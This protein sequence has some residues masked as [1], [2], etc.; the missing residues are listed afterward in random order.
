MS[1]AQK[2][3][4]LVT[5]NLPPL[6]GGMENLLLHCA[7]TLCSHY[8]LTVVGPKGCS[9]YL[10]DSIEVHEVSSNL[11]GFLMLAPIYVLVSL[12]RNRYHLIFGGSGLMAPSCWLF[13]K[14]FGVAT[15]C[16]V[17]GLDIVVNSRIY[18]SIFVPCLRRQSSIIVNSSNTWRLC[19]A[20]GIDQGKIAIIHPGC[21]IPPATDRVAA[22]RFLQTYY[23]VVSDFCMLFVGRVA[24]RKGL[25]AF[26]QHGFAPLLLRR[27]DTVL[28]IAGDSPD[29]S[30]AHRGDE[31][32]NVLREVEKNAWTDRVYFLGKV[33]NDTL[34]QCYAGADCLLFPLVPVVG[35]VEG[36]GMVAI[37][38]A[39]RGTLT[40]AFAEGG[41]SD[42]VRDGV[43]G[44]LIPSG[45]YNAMIDALSLLANDAET[46]SACQNH[47]AHFGWDVF[48]IKLLRKFNEVIS[49]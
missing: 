4:L 21:D 23:N 34:A 33:D 9:A 31:L 36:F 39:A 17:H 28:V 41:V 6:V 3:I 35:D 45:D 16:Y 8:A 18:Q 27:P 20:S 1:S 37:E 29:E 19:I 30:L 15:L 40:V 42:A 24:P 44:C 26:L 14:T 10:D 12:C 7:N 2:R 11:T 13:G 43:S 5:R 48:D 49:D 32:E 22:R 38:A 47:A 46:V 25:L